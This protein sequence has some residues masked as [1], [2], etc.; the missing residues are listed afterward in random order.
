MTGLI[1]RLQAD[2]HLPLLREGLWRTIL[3][4]DEAG[5]WTANDVCRRTNLNNGSPRMYVRSL[6]NAGI[7]KVVGERLVKTRNLQP[8]ALYRLTQRP[9]DAPR[10]RRDGSLVPEREIERFWRAMKMAKVF[11]C[12]EIADYV[13]VEGRVIPPAVV[14]SYA[15][16]LENVGVLAFA[17]WGSP[18]PEGGQRPRQ[19]RIA[20]NVGAKAPKILKAHVVFDPNARVVLGTPTAVEVSP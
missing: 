13:S 17:G 15:K 16:R 18:P 8:A 6:L 3:K 9:I 12:R 10:V 11:T 4:L 2:L 19:Y 5:P 14:Q 1:E 7:V 20:R